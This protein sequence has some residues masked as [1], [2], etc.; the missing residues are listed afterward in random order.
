MGR[1]PRRNYEM[2]WH[3]QISTFWH[4]NVGKIDSLFLCMYVYCAWNRLYLLCVFVFQT[5]EMFHSQNYFSIVLPMH[6]LKKYHSI[7][8]I[9]LLCIKKYELF[10]KQNNI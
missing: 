6:L 7:S 5:Y 1:A 3:F 9:W 10:L 4:L 8:N 2:A